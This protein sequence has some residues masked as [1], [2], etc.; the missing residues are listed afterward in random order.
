MLF[1]GLGCIVSCLWVTSRQSVSHAGRLLSI[2]VLFQHSGKSVHGKFVPKC[3]K[4]A[5]FI[6]QLIIYKTSERKTQKNNSNVLTFLRSRVQSVWQGG[7]MADGMLSGA[8]TQQQLKAWRKGACKN[9][10][11]QTR[12]VYSDISY[13]N[14][15]TLLHPR[16]FNRVILGDW[17]R[18]SILG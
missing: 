18:V 1:V 9:Q 16:Q 2:R 10:V 6:E 8:R 12:N 7:G 3:W 14:R 4:R 5:I 17:I 15:S 13:A 11:R